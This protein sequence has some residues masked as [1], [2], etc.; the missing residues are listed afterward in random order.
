MHLIPRTVLDRL[1]QLARAGYPEETCGLLVG[2]KEATT[3]RIERATRAGNLSAERRCDRY[4]L[5]PADFLAADEAARRDGLDLLGVWH[6]HPDHPA[7]P[8]ATDLAAAWEGFSYLI[9]SVGPSGVA[10]SRVWIL[11]GSRFVEQPIEETEP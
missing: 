6:T 10:E 7:I 9:L 8:S 2:R 1:E 4:V 3:V 5:D 11:D